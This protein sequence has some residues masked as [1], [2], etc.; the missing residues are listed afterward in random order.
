MNS[1]RHRLLALIY[2]F[3]CLGSA[4]VYGQRYSFQ[5]LSVD[6]G[7]IQSQPMCMVQDSM[8]IYGWGHLVGF[9]VTT[10]KVSPIIA[11]EMD[12]SVTWCKPSQ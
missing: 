2:L 3:L 11:F 10:V 6:D 4:R 8:G 7:L 1:Y 5:N 9:R 12:Y